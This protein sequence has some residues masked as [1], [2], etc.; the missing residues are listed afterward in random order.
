ML[1]Y[2]KHN[3][4]CDVATVVG[5]ATCSLWSSTSRDRTSEVFGKHCQDSIAWTFRQTAASVHHIVQTGT[6]WELVLHCYKQSI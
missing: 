6:L 1:F 2:C 5:L 3:P 4:R